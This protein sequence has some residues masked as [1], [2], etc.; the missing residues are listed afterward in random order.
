MLLYRRQKMRQAIQRGIPRKADAAKTGSFT[1]SPGKEAQSVIAIIRLNQ[2]ENFSRNKSLVM[3]LNIECI[4]QLAAIVIIALSDP[5]SN[6]EHILFV[7]LHITKTTLQ[8][9]KNFYYPD[10]LLKEGRAIRILKNVRRQDDISK[11]L[12][13]LLI[14]KN[15]K[16]GQGN[17]HPLMLYRRRD[18]SSFGFFLTKY[19]KEGREIR[20]L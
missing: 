20:I 12:I 1:K 15:S 18:I 5:Q 13:Y 10:T 17:P 19:P 14:S 6:P 3:S 11:S 8:Y 7:L 9:L 4:Y 16:G 2:G